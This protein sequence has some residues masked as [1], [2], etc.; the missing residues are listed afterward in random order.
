MKNCILLFCVCCLLTGCGVY[1]TTRYYV[2]VDAQQA[3]FDTTRPLKKGASCSFLLLGFIPWPWH[4]H[5]TPDTVLEAL[6][7]ANIQKLVWM[8]TTYDYKFTY[9][10]A[11]RNVYGY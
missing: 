8:D 5:K 10:N 11:C 3:R 6:Q 1:A 2:Q 7:Q 9:A 4:K